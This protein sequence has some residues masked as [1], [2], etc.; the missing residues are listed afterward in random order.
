[1]KAYMWKKVSKEEFEKFLKEYP[2]KLESD[3]FM[4]WVSWND[5]SEGKVW[6]ESMIAMQ[7]D[8]TYGEPIVYKIKVEYEE[9]EEE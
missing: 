1:M 6:P 8:C 4:D 2:N 5:F 7:S 3:W 9:R